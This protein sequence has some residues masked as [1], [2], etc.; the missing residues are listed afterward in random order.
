MENLKM[1][2]TE[3]IKGRANITIEKFMKIHKNNNPQFEGNKI[4]IYDGCD[5][6]GRAEVITFDVV[7]DTIVRELYKDYCYEMVNTRKFFN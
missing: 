2:C 5:C 7:E 1:I 4:V 3:Y 6:L